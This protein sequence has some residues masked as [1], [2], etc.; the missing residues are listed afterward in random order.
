MATRGT[1]ARLEAAGIVCD[2][3]NK[4]HEGRPHC[5]DEMVSGEIDFVVN[6]T[7]GAEEIRDSFSLRRTAL[8]RGISY[9]TTIRGAEA[10]LAG[11]SAMRGSAASASPRTLQEY[12]SKKVTTHG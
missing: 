2:K 5:V 7:E 6:T 4:V 1:A 11:I 12:H 8:Q 3:V 10:A 9:F